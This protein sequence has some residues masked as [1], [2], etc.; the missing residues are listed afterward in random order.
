MLFLFSN[1]YED[2]QIEVVEVGGAFGAFLVLTP[3]GKTPMEDTSDVDD[4]V[5]LNCIL[6]KKRKT[7]GMDLSGSGMRPISGFFNMVVNLRV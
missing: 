2:D 6:R 1:Y 7:I 5:T 4:R 3:E